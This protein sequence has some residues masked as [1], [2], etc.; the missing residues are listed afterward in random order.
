MSNDSLMNNKGMSWEITQLGLRIVW[1]GF[2][3][4]SSSTAEY[5]M[6]LCIL[7]SAFERDLQV[8]TPCTIFNPS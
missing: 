3:R 7:E 1:D 5:T 6:A 4:G 2:H 8:E